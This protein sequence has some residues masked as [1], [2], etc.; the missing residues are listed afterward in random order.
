M[1]YSTKKSSSGKGAIQVMAEN[2]VTG[3]KIETE[4]IFWDQKEKRIY[5]EK[6]SKVTNPDGVFIGE[7][8]FEADEDLSTLRLNGYSG[9]VTVRDNPENMNQLF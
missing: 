9:K 1:L 2:L 4:Q 7:N 5:S 6:F 3:E 8:G